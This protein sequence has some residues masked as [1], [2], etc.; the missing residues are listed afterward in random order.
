MKSMWNWLSSAAIILPLTLAT[1]CP[2]P[3]E[4]AEATTPTEGTT[5]AEGEAPAEGGGD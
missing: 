5:P 2:P 3:Q 1:G 4:P